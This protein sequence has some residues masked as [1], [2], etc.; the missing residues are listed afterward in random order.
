L[1]KYLWLYLQLCIWILKTFS[2][3]VKKSFFLHLFQKKQ[4][5]KKK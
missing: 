4:L 5:K 3:F 2:V 1:G